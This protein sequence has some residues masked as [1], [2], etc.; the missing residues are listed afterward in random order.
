[1]HINYNIQSQLEL[2]KFNLIAT[3]IFNRAFENFVVNILL[4]HMKY[5]SYFVS[6]SCDFGAGIIVMTLAR[7]MALGSWYQFWHM[8]HIYLGT[9]ILADQS[10]AG[11]SV[12]FFDPWHHGL[13]CDI[14]SP[15]MLQLLKIVAL[16]LHKRFQ[17]RVFIYGQI[18]C[19]I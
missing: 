16:S 2:K 11:G 4:I 15:K 9:Y 8:V 6:W 13:Q 17:F 10:L 5:F 12:A 3:Y 1:M 7:V 14:I 19:Y 18:M